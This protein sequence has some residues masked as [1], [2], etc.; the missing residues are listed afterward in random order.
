M[1]KQIL[2]SA[3]FEPTTSY[4]R[5]KRFHE[6]RKILS[7]YYNISSGAV[8]SLPLD[9][10]SLVGR[11]CLLQ[12]QEVVGSKPTEGIKICFS[13]F[14]LLLIRVTCGELFCKTNVKL[15]KLITIL[16]R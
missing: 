7:K 14:T 5:G 16:F 6:R 4:I 2:P 11:S 10:C 8:C 15:L 13:Y 9:P 1:L 3:K 12:M